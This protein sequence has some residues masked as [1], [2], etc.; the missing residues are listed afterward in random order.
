MRINTIYLELAP[1][2]NYNI[3]HIE[4]RNDRNRISNLLQKIDS[5]H[6]NQEE[7]GSLNDIL[8][9]YNDIFHLEGGIQHRNRLLHR[10]EPGEPISI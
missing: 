3:L 10:K 9:E 5:S 7:I 8:A 1:I 2:S 6:L 4:N